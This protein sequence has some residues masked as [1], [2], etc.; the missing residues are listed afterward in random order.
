MYKDYTV[1]SNFNTFL[2]F[3]YKSGYMI[4]KTIDKGYKKYISTSVPYFLILQVYK[5]FLQFFL[6]L[7][8]YYFISITIIIIIY[9]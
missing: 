2:L 6:H 7:L 8:F 5:T 4:L 9:I 3:T 1:L